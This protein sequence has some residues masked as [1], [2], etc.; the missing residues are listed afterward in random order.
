MNLLA[1]R[2]QSIPRQRV[3]VLAAN[4][5][6]DASDFRIDDIQSVTIPVRPDQFLKEGWHDFTMV[7]DNRSIRPDQQVCIP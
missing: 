3:S 5:R 2:N 1:L 4:Q 7:I 6:A